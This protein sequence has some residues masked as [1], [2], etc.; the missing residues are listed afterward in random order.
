[1]IAHTTHTTTTETMSKYSIVIRQ[2]NTTGNE[3]IWDQLHTDDAEAGRAWIVKNMQA[4]N[5]DGTCPKVQTV[6]NGRVPVT[7]EVFR[8]D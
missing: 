1:M 5:T 8:N 7:C 6:G 3:G 2:I 4:L